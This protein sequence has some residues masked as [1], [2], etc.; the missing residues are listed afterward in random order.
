M[1]ESSF[2]EIELSRC[3]GTQ[4][5]GQVHS[6]TGLQGPWRCTKAV[7]EGH[8]DAACQPPG[9]E[10]QMALNVLLKLHSHLFWRR[11][12]K[13]AA[14]ELPKET[15]WVFKI[16]TVYG[17]YCTRVWKYLGLPFMCRLSGTGPRAYPKDFFSKRPVCAL[18]VQPSFLR[19]SPFA[20]NPGE[21]SRTWEPQEEEM[22]LSELWH[23]V[24]GDYFL[25]LN[26]F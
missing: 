5:D 21:G 1:P 24:G 13:I 12:A 22:A 14:G 25:F 17:G 2:G 4:A 16:L 7:V 15:F 23:P 3:T 10:E 9:V 8:H 20:L 6:I 18:W 19:Q 26:L 11:A